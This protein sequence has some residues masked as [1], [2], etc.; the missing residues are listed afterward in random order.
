ML[1]TLTDIARRYCSIVPSSGSHPVGLNSTSSPKRAALL[2]RMSTVPNSAN[3]AW[4]MPSTAPGSANAHAY[5]LPMP[6]PL[7]VTM[8]TRLIET[9]L[10]GTLPTASSE[11]SL[12]RSGNLPSRQRLAER[13][14][15]GRGR[16]HGSR[17]SRELVISGALPRDGPAEPRHDHGTRHRR[18]GRSSFPP[19]TAF[20]LGLFPRHTGNK[21]C[22]KV[23]AV[24]R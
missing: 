8:A 22:T 23:G 21:A 14:Q 5:P 15:V 13:S 10:P 18:A 2:T 11:H 24:A 20:A 6:R 7:P 17:T 16:V 19:S 12:Y 9:L 4:T 3:V 1:S